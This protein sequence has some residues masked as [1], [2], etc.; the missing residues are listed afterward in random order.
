[1]NFNEYQE[2]AKTTALY[3]DG[4]KKEFPD[5]P[6]KIYKLLGISYVSNGLGETGEVQGKIKKIIRDSN[7]NI[8]EE[9]KKEIGKELGDVIWYVSQMCEELG[10]SFQDVAEG[11]IEKLFSRKERNVLKGSGDNR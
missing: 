3:L 10:I 8:T 2:K 11:N 9:H 6:Q 7:G 1:M 4:I 5:L